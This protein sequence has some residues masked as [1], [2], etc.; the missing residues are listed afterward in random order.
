[1]RS[2]N[3]LHVIVGLGKTGLSCV[4]Y[5]RKQ[6]YPVAVTDSRTNPPGLDELTAQYPDVSVS[7]GGLSNE[8]CQKADVLVVSP[9][10]SLHEPVIAAAMQKGI[11]VIGDIELFARHAKAPIVAITGSNG[12]S[13]VTSLLG[14]M[15]KCSG[16]HVKVG[17]NLGTP[18]LNLLSDAEPDL[19]VIELSSFQLETTYSLRAAAAVVLNI[20]ADHMD[21]YADLVEYLVAKQRI[22]HHCK[23]AVVNR[24]DPLSWKGVH[25]ISHFSQENILS[26][27]LDAP[28]A[29][30]VGLIFNESQEFI[31]IGKEPLIATTALKIKGRHQIANALAAVALGYALQLSKSA[32]KQALQEFTGLAHRCQFVAHYDGVDWYNDSKATN[33]GAA[34]AVI[35]GL[36]AQIKG[37]L[38]VIAGGLGKNADFRPLQDI[39]KTHVRHLILLGRDADKMQTA[40]QNSTEIHR[41]DTMEQAV[42]LAKQKAQPQDVV[43]LAPACASWDMFQN[44]EQR[45]EV[46]MAAVRALS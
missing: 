39:M 38:I 5:L 6:G 35:A 34:Q 20:S 7:M 17:G 29:N 40:L 8:L 36:G 33:V 41:V 23:T 30:Q 11:E 43:I 27:G 10:L 4:H 46:Y 14:E 44:F 31:S 15:A 3:K 42:Q 45:G 25:A 24:D 2:K 16:L 19:Y 26:F 22:Y 1:M 21:R 18:A 12:K 28:K 32:M 9:G 37:K 13:T